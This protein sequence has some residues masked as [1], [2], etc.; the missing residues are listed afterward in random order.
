V[1]KDDYCQHV[2]DSYRPAESLLKMVPEDKLDWKSASSFMSLG[3]LIY[4][5]SGGIGPE[6]SI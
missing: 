5:L 1:K 3:Q 6:L 4:H 2:L